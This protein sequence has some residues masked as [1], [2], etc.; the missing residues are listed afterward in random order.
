MRRRIALLLVICM[1]TSMLPT[2]LAEEIVQIPNSEDVALELPSETEGFL[3]DES[4]TFELGDIDLTEPD[5]EGLEQA[6]DEVEILLDEEGESVTSEDNEESGNA[7][8]QAFPK[9]L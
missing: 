8:T 1:L 6:D 4:T 5:L 3:E 7:T 2:A 9:T